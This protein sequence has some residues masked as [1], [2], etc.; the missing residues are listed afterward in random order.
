MVGSQ[1][2]IT[3]RGGAKAHTY[4]PI[5]VHLKKG[6]QQRSITSDLAQK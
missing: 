2:D 5:P 4:S 1:L 3:G 6:R